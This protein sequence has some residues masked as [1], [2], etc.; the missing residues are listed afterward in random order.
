M[1][2]QMKNPASGAWCRASLV[3]L[4][5]AA[6]GSDKDPLDSV[7]AGVTNPGATHPGGD[8][9]EDGG[10]TQGATTD[11][12]DSE[13]AICDA[14]LA[15]VAAA[16]PETLADNEASFGPKGSCWQG[17]PETIEQC[18][19]TCAEALESFGM[20]YPDE[21]ACNGGA[22]STT[23]EPSTTTTTTDPSCGESRPNGDD[24]GPGGDCTCASG[25][26]HPTEDFGGICS[27][28]AG[29]GDC[30]G[31]VCV[32]SGNGKGAVCRADGPGEQCLE[33][34]CLDP[35]APHCTNIIGYNTCS[36]CRTDDDCPA[37]AP[38]CTP[39][40]D[41]QF[42]SIG[43]F[44][45]RAVGSV[46]LHEGCEIFSQTGADACVTGLCA[47]VDAGQLIIGVCSECHS[48]KHCPSGE[49]ILGAA[50]LDTGKL[51]GRT[52]Q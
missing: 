12:G 49:C 37:Q 50:N 25:K 18:L 26:C 30:P 27:A 19:A 38:I 20:L 36:E 9:T 46:P 13:H 52:C 33:G 41:D 7:G 17:L 44:R 31:E 39:T 4:M 16:A 28:C 23:G 15:C 47:Q 42:S 29:D 22:G 8:P 40:Y 43:M 48:D 2:G 10:T 34:S 51:T 24:C 11:A 45:C 14:Y 6:C 21:P 35:S 5:L 32:W 3:G 1:I